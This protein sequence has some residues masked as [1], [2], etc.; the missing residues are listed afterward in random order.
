MG[1]GIP[2]DSWLRGPLRGWA[3]AL[4]DQ[5]RLVEEGFFRPAAVR[6][7]WTA[8]MRGDSRQQFKLWGI[9]MFQ[10]W[11]EAQDL[12][13]SRPEMERAALAS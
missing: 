2:L 7:A 4:I 9:L 10:A 8:L 13:K 5:R 3:E 12:Q 11:L 6:D 1:F